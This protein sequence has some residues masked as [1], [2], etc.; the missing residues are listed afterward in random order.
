MCPVIDQ[1][2]RHNIVK[3]AVDV[4]GYRVVYPQ[5][6]LT[7]FSVTKYILKIKTGHL[8]EKLPSICLLQWQIIKLYALVV[9]YICVSW[10]MSA[11]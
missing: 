1:E 8:H 7:M 2:F 5:T 3:V 10:P 6:T 11:R 4:L 9:S